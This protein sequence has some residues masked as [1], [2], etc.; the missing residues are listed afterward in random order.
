MKKL[1]TNYFINIVGPQWPEWVYNMVA[2]AGVL[3]AILESLHLH[4]QQYQGND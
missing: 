1:L 2:C 3:T 4:S